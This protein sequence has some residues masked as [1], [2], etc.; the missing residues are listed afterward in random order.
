MQI[1]AGG[2]VLDDL[3]SGADSFEHPSKR[4]KMSRACKNMCITPSTAA[5]LAFLAGHEDYKNRY[6]TLTF[7]NQWFSGLNADAD[8]LREKLP[9]LEKADTA[10][11]ITPKERKEPATAAVE[12]VSV[13]KIELV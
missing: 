9:E 3:K 1:A 2:T 6:E 10:L 8:E 4:A 7:E 12:R 11:R 13:L 5:F